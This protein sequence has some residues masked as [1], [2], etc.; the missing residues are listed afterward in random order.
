MPIIEYIKTTKKIKSAHY[1]MTWNASD[2]TS[3]ESDNPGQ[4]VIQ[5]ADSETTTHRK[6]LQVNDGVGTLHDT[7]LMTISV[8]VS[9]NERELYPLLSDN[10]AYIDFTSVPEG[11]TCL[12]DGTNAGT[13]DASGIFRFTA[14]H[15]G[16]YGVSFELTAY[17]TEYFGVEASDNI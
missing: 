6:Y 2:W 13:M 7:S 15:A 12:V 8:S 11:A 17:E 16:T 4:A 1:G 10:S 9:A 14:Q 3:Y 5:V